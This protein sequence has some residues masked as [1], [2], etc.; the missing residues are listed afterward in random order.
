MDA[1]S[2]GRIVFAEMLGTFVLMLG[3]PG[4][5]VIAGDRVGTAGVALGF[6]LS[7]MVMVYVIGPISGCHVNPAVS[8]ALLLA[9][10]ISPVRAA[11]SV[12]GQVMGA[13]GGGAAVYGLA[14][15]ADGFS[16]GNFASNL[17]TG[18]FHGFGAMVG[19]EITLTAVLVLVVLRIGSRGFPGFL[20][21]VVAGL[22]LT[23]IPLISIPVDNTSVNPAR[24]LGTALFADTGSGALEQLWAFVVFPLVGAV[25]GVVVWLVLDE[26]RLEDTALAEVPG[27][28]ATRDRLD[29][30]AGEAVGAVADTIDPHHPHPPH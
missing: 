24:S 13:I 16:R 3:G 26:R 1:R 21:G 27:L 6:G 25:V 15:G 29:R 5:A 9:R 8:L 23:L 12:I 30:V 10:R 11:M 2:L 4:T 28:A 19:A 14:A 18:E 20:G 7:L 22:T 17:W